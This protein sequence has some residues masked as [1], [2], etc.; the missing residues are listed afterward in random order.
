[1]VSINTR[2]LGWNVVGMALFICII[3]GVFWSV[4]PGGMAPLAPDAM[5]W[6]SFGYR[7]LTLD[8][9]LTSGGEVTPHHLYW[10]LFPPLW[11]NKL[12]YIIDTL[13][14]VLAGVYYLRGRGASYASA[15]LGGLALGFSGYSFT[16]FSAG[17][18]GYFHMMG[19]T[20]FAFGLLTRCFNG[21]Q[22]FHFAMLG[23]CL[24]WGLL[25]QP[26]VFVMIV[27]LAGAYAL[28]LT[29]T[30]S[31]DMRT[32]W[33][34]VRQVYP[35]FLLSLLVIAVIAWSGIKNVLGQQITGRK[36]QIAAA[37]GMSTDAASVTA[38]VDAAVKQRE[39]WIF[40]T[41]WSLPPE[42][43]LEFVAPGVFG[44]DSFQP[45]YP[46]WGRLGRPYGWQPGQPPFP[47]YR[48]HTVYLGVA[49]VLFAW[50][51]VFAWW[52][53]RHPAAVG[54]RG[55][56]TTAMLTDVPFWVAAGVIC[57][58]LAM[59]RYTPFYRLFYAIPYMDLIR[60]PVKFH[61]LVEICTAFLFGLGVE[62]WLRSQ[63]GMAGGSAKADGSMHGAG[64]FA[65]AMRAAMIGA[66]V[67]A[68]LLLS[69]AGLAVLAREGVIEYVTRL[70]LGQVAR[71]LADYF[72]INL[73]RGALLAF[74]VAGL[75]WQGRPRSHRPRP[76]VWLITVLALM[77]TVDLISV[78][79]RFVR[80]LN[81]GPFYAI[82]AVTEA[83]TQQGGV[84]T[85]VAN[86][87]TANDPGR[88]WFA[89]ALLRNGLR[90]SLSAD[91]NSVEGRIA[92]A[93]GRRPE[94]FW[95]A[96][97]TR[98]VTAK[99]TVAEPFV[100]SGV[101]RPMLAFKLGQGSVQLVTPTADAYVLAEY[102]K[103]LPEAYVVNCWR[104]G[105]GEAAQLQ[106]MTEEGWDSMVT[107]VSDTPAGSA[108]T[109]TVGR[110]IGQTRLKQRRGWN[111]RLST[112]AEVDHTQPGLLV[113]DEPYASGLEVRVDGRAT[114]LRRANGIWAAVEVPAGRH[115]IVFRHM[116]SPLLPIISA[117]AGVA[118]GLW[119][120]YICVVRLRTNVL[121]SPT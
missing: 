50:L 18:R 31:I 51:A 21:R 7:T 22:W 15:W 59:G 64:A 35:R 105:L 60:C 11:A 25:Y 97:H 43:A 39:Q 62:V 69:M 8:N 84:G 10:L 63:C 104:G 85:T 107:V 32:T 57:L 16:L 52:R 30:H 90:L 78:G 98:F 121:S 44:N 75:L 114:P 19:C 117:L 89:S 120:L 13:M 72:T 82:N 111:F 6:F 113:L 47:N 2:T 28:W 54:E 34:C 87:V 9:L 119:G 101:L 33:Q 65:W 48:Q 49:Q 67:L 66:T 12:T 53:R 23:A 38:P 71:P 112:I 29:R 3:L 41:N 77:V 81:L 56:N 95:R 20:V 17:H 115:T 99:W 106:A 24:A 14:L 96:S 58:L 76:N 80:P 88:D 93:F 108:A 92:Q 26:D 36:E 61:H 70:N 83:V 102:V 55:D 103:A 118:M 109:G 79:R 91:P 46:Y 68:V 110:V 100:R 40:A 74:V 45:P 37:A 73:L 42:D 5:P 27:M 4:L 86:Y 1:M 94:T 116:L